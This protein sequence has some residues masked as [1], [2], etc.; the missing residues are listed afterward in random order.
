VVNPCQR[1]HNRPTRGQKITLLQSC[2]ATGNFFLTR[3]AA[4]SRPIRSAAVSHCR[5][6]I[7]FLTI[8][9]RPIISKSTRP[10]FTNFSGL[11]ELLASAHRGKWGQ[12]SPVEKNGLKNKKQKDAKKI[13][14]LYLCYI[15]R[16]IRAGRCRERRYADHIFIQI[17]F[18]MHHFVVKFSKFSSPHE[19]Q[20]GIDPPL[21]K[22]LRMFLGRT[23]AVDERSEISFSIP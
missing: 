17:Y 5:A 20:G 15:L 10:I 11:V 12:L 8:S 23:T 22:I 2:H 6:Y 16:A 7:Y 3:P 4:E 21:T 13:S 19:W 18:T 9:V 14:F 1:Q